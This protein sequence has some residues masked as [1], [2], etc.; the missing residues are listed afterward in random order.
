MYTGG[1]EWRGNQTAEEEEP[2]SVKARREAIAEWYMM[3]WKVSVARSSLRNSRAFSAVN[4]TPLF[5]A[6]LGL[7]LGLGLGF[8]AF[9]V[10]ASASASIEDNEEEEEEEAEKIDGSGSLMV[11]KRGDHQGFFFLSAPAIISTTPSSP[12]EQEMAAADRTII[13]DLR[14]GGREIESPNKGF[15]AKVQGSILVKLKLSMITKSEYSS[16]NPVLLWYVI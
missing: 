10:S 3:S 12:E 9:L 7:G 14:Q 16:F 13:I 11:S 1:G 4:P 15:F 8:A 6:T 5:L 2:S